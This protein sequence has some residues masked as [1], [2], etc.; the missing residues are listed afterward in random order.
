[1]KNE[2]PSSRDR[3]QAFQARNL[4][5][6]MTRGKPG[7]ELLDLSNPMLTI[8]DS[9]HYHAAG[10]NDCRNYGILDGLP[11]AKNLFADYMD[12]APEEILIA[13]NASLNL[14]Y[15]EVVRSM[16]YGVPGGQSP[17]IQQGT[18]KF[19]C[20]V[21]GYDRHFNI[22]SVL[23]IEMINVPMNDEG[24]DM[25]IVEKLVGEDASIKGIWCVPRYSNPNGVIYSDRVIDRFAQM[26]TA[27]PDFRIF[28]DN[29]YRH[30]HLVENPRDQKNLLDACKSAGVAQRAL[31]FGSTSKIT[32]AGGGL[33]FLAANKTN[34]DHTRKY[35]ANQT[36]GYDKLNQLRHVR[37]FGDLAGLRKHMNQHRAILKPKFDA[38]DSVLTSELDG[39]D[40]AH[41]TRPEGGYFVSLDTRPGLA[42][43]VVALAADVGVKLTAAGATYPGGIDPEDRNIRISPSLPGLEEIE[44]ATEVLAVCIILAS[45]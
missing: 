22:C 43:K 35:L 6:D 34:M 41:W 20:P 1:M 18:I 7:P 17:W 23:G 12:V 2:L 10:G 30:H 31:M 39:K 8:V 40:L 4:K 27:A 33:S 21:P 9:E 13:G 45:E 19:L 38:V 14:M 24:P 37:F 25:H 44:L 42:K 15:D 32:F 26:K 11:E 28:W 36:I 3:Y 16:L 29:A 5:L